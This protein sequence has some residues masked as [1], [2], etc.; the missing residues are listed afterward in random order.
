[1]HT[2][3][4]KW[5]EFYRNVGEQNCNHLEFKECVTLSEKVAFFFMRMTSVL[6]LQVKKT[7][8]ESDVSEPQN[9]RYDDKVNTSLRKIAVLKNHKVIAL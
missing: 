3:A 1:M 6:F 5:R 8:P 2:I 9:S 4:I 7:C